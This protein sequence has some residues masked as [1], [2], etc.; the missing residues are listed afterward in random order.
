MSRRLPPRPMIPGCP[1]N[2]ATTHLRAPAGCACRVKPATMN[3]GYKYS[4]LCKTEK[5]IPMS[6]TGYAQAVGGSFLPIVKK[7]NGFKTLS[8]A[9]I[10]RDGPMRPFLS[11]WPD[12]SAASKYAAT[13]L[14]ALTWLGVRFTTY[15]MNF[16]AHPFRR[17]AQERHF[18]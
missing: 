6:S 5:V 12:I 15:V 1:M 18:I 14:A 3:H 10:F 9:V 2:T 7:A 17:G 13:H 4:F 11:C 16:A 8:A